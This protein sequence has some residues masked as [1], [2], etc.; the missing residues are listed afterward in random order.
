MKNAEAVMDV[1]RLETILCETTAMLRDD[2]Q[3]GAGYEVVDCI[4]K[5]VGV[6]KEKAEGFKGEL[7]RIMRGYPLPDRLAL[8]PSSIELAGTIFNDDQD[9]AF[10]LM[11]TGKVAGLWN[12]ITPDDL[13]IDSA[14]AKR[15]AT[16][17]AVAIDGFGE[18]K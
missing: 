16:N 11:A 6:L 7:E 4:L 2:E 13:G 15:L 12:L 8:G 14:N 17:G 18:K 1:S 9:L 3:P 10:R 5:R